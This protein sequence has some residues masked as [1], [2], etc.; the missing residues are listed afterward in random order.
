M[1]DMGFCQPAY[2]RCRLQGATLSG[3]RPVELTGYHN[4]C[5]MYAGYDALS[6]ISPVERCSCRRQVQKEEMAVVWAGIEDQT[7]SDYR[8]RAARS[9]KRAA[10]RGYP[11]RDGLLDRHLAGDLAVARVPGIALSW[12][13]ATS[14]RAVVALLDWALDSRLSGTSERCCWH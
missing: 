3:H 9:E 8:D 5:M 11:A 10:L 2:T 14:T 7:L 12:L 13:R 1:V 6:Q 4:R